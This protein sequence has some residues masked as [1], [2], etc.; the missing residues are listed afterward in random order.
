MARA[1]IAKLLS[2]VGAAA[3]AGAAQAQPAWEAH[4]A[5]SLTG[6]GS[7]ITPPILFLNATGTYTFYVRVGIYSLTGQQPGQAN[8]GLAALS[9]QIA[10]TGLRAGEAIG[11]TPSSC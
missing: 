8:H 10:A 7:A 5:F 1:R 6:G 11:Y 2:S 4:A 9:G 3:L